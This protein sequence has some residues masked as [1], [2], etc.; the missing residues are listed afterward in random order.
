MIIVY[1][2]NNA[3]ALLLLWVMLIALYAALHQCQILWLFNHP[4]KEHL[5]LMVKMY[6]KWTI[7]L[8]VGYL[9]LYN[10]KTYYLH[11]TD[12]VNYIK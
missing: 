8:L 7:H 9:Q 2:I 5:I 10:N 3:N 6:F 4:A 12:Q 1:V 11:F